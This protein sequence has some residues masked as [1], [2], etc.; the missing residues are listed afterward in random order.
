ME[1]KTRK[2]EGNENLFADMIVLMGLH[3]EYT[4]RN[5]EYDKEAFKT[6]YKENKCNFV[7]RCTIQ[8]RVIRKCKK[9]YDENDEHIRITRGK[10]KRSYRF[11]KHRRSFVL[12]NEQYYFWKYVMDYIVGNDDLLD[13]MLN[14]DLVYCNSYTPDTDDMNDFQQCLLRILDEYYIR[15]TMGNGVVALGNNYRRRLR[16]RYK[17]YDQMNKFRIACRDYMANK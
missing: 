11:N 5:S 6:Y 12:R 16:E 9:Y 13:I 10:V 1:Y 2:K 3:L 15:L 4:H 14:E 7:H 17:S 8:S